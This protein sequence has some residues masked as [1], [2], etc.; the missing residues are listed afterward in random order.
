MVNNYN[1]ARYGLFRHNLLSAFQVKDFRWYWVSVFFSSMSMGVRMLAQGWLILD[2]TGSP[3]WVGVAAGIGGVGLVIFGAV[4]GT[5]VDRFDKK[6]VLCVLYVF[7]ATVISTI[8]FLVIYDRIVLWHILLGAFFQGIVMAAQQPAVNS[9]A[10]QL[11][12]SNRLLNAMAARLLAMNISRIIGSVIAGYLIYRF[13]I[14]SSY[15]FA[16]SCSI[17]GLGFLYFVKVESRVLGSTNESFWFS[18]KQ[19]IK[20][21]FARKNIRELLLLSLIMEAFGFS[22]LIILPVVAKDV[23]FV[24]AMGLG[25]LS[26]ASGVGAT[27]STLLVAFLGDFKYKS[28]LLV[29]TAIFSGVGLVLFAF[30][31]WFILSTILVAWVGGSLM[32]YDVTMGTLIQLSSKE[33]MRGRVLGVYGLT[34]GFT[35]VGGFFMGWISSLFSAPIAIATGGIIVM[36][37]MV[38]VTRYLVK[39]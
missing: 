34:F 16:S 33:E 30:S 25:I 27:V 8:G 36:A 15:V 17:V 14:G 21:I 39:L 7:G 2:L 29:T 4:G 28:L 12:G 19:G 11:V 26:A 38:R 9:I 10:H 32:A 13:G 24:D 22:H 23:L 31:N 3:F 5:I 6:M 18:T 1:N 20:Y 35:P 37:Y